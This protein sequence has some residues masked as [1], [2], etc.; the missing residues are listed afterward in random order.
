MI[1]PD[2]WRAA[3]DFFEWRG[4]RIYYRVAGS[5]DPLLLVHGFPTASWDYHA[6]WEPLVQRYRVLT[7]DMIGFGLSAKP[8]DF[9]YSIL[10]QADLFEEL[11]R[12]EQVGSYRLVA[13]DYG[14]SVAQEL[15]ARQAEGASTTLISAC[16]LNGGLFPE[17]HRPLR[18]QKLLA[19]P[20]GPLIARVA[21]FRTF[22]RSMRR[23]WGTKSV[24]DHELH[25]M[26]QLVRTNDGMR[27]MPQII[28]YLAERR[29]R[30]ERWV[31]ALVKTKVPL[32]L[33]NGPVDP[34]AG[35]R[36]VAR[37][38]ELVP[39]PDVVELPG[40]GHYPQVEAP[41]AV[42]SAILER[43]T[44]SDRPRSTE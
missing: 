13:H 3:G 41:G 24:S 29:Q 27:V 37:Y 5:G 35:E 40:V 18:T 9:D 16:L 8:A 39:N 6:L 32:R 26:W 11:L 1:T 44:A 31:G 34:V 12:R 42:L 2:D 19:S 20:L 10:A 21:S 23:I 22:G 33:I 7:L 36:I 14:V 15:L 38:R 4:H 43:F 30:R 17:A 25:A 28:R